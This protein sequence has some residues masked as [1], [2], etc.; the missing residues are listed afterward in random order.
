MGTPSLFCSHID[1]STT[2][3][4]LIFIAHLN[5][6]QAHC[7]YCDLWLPLDGRVLEDGG[8]ARQKETGF[9]IDLEEVIPPLYLLFKTLYLGSLCNMS[10]VC[11]Q[12]NIKW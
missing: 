11:I 3:V 5:L 9:L 8:A 6:D 4:H 7:R 1:Y 2:S 12:T 10:L